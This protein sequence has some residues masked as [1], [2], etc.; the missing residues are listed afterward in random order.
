MPRKQWKGNQ[1]GLR[2]LLY[3]SILFN[4][5]SSYQ[6]NSTPWQPKLPFVTAAN[7]LH[8]ASNNHPVTSDSKF[9]LDSSYDPPNLLSQNHQYC[10]ETHVNNFEGNGVLWKE[11]GWEV[12][13]GF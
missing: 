3:D 2:F 12:T 1:K 8:S 5:A 4:A 9:Y 10:H 6:L 7:V 11:H 13:L